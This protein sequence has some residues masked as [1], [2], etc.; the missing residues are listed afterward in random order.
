MGVFLLGLFVGIPLQG[1]GVITKETFMS[2][3]FMPP[4]YGA[5]IIASLFVIGSLS[6]VAITMIKAALNGEEL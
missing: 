2:F 3:I 5:A 6:Y 4:L 1:F